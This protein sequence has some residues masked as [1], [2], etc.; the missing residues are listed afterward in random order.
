MSAPITQILYEWMVK[1]RIVSLV[2]REMG[3]NPG[4]LSAELRTH[5]PH[6]KLGADD[7]VPLCRAICRAGYEKELRGLLH[8]FVG[9]LMGQAADTVDDKQFVPSVLNLSRCVGLLSESATRLNQIEDERELAGIRTMIRTEL[10][11]V[12]MLMDAIV[13]DRIVK[14]RRKRKQADREFLLSAPALER[15]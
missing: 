10:L 3:V 12:A 7:L 13:A 14:L 15:P 6:A 5:N 1:R 8:P 11:S 9:E 2:A 4:T